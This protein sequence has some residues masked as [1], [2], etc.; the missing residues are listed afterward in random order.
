[1]IRVLA[2]LPL[3]AALGCSQTHPKADVERGQRALTA[4]LDSWKNNEPPDRTRSLPE[5]VEYIDE[6]RSTFKLT[7]YTIGTPVTT[8]PEIIRFPVS[9]KLQDRKG[10]PVHRDVMFEVKLAT[11]VVI[12]RDPYY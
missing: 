6:L 5:P 10:K 3:L 1:M 9:L 11:P 2:F 4:A 7:E 12:A 8:D